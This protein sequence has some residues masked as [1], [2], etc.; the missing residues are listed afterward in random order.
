MDQAIY[1]SADQKLIDDTR[2]IYTK[3]CRY[4]DYE[5]LNQLGKEKITSING[6]LFS[7]EEIYGVNNKD[8]NLNYDIDT[9]AKQVM[10][11]YPNLLN[12]ADANIMITA[13]KSRLGDTDDFCPDF[14]KFSEYK[15]S[16]GNKQYDFEISKDDEYY[17]QLVWNLNFQS[18]FS[19]MNICNHLFHTTLSSEL[20]PDIE[21]IS[22]SNSTLSFSYYNKFLEQWKTTIIVQEAIRY[23]LT[24]DDWIY[25]EKQKEYLQ[26]LNFMPLQGDST[27]Y[28][29]KYQ[30]NLKYMR[31]LYDLNKG[32]IKNI[33]YI[34]FAMFNKQSEST[35][36]EL[37]GRPQL[38][39][40]LDWINSIY[41]RFQDDIMSNFDNFMELSGNIFS[42]GIESMLQYSDFYDFDFKDDPDFGVEYFKP[43][44]DTFI[45]GYKLP[46][47][48][49]K[50][51][52]SC[53]VPIEYPKAFSKDS[54]NKRN[55]EETTTKQLIWKA[56]DS[57]PLF[58]VGKN[59]KGYIINPK[60]YKYIDVFEKKK[61]RNLELEIENF[62]N[63]FNNYSVD[64]EKDFDPKDLAHNYLESMNK[65]LISLSGEKE[66][67]IQSRPWQL[68][69]PINI[70][71]EEFLNNVIGYRVLQN[72]LTDSWRHAARWFGEASRNNPIL[73]PVYQNITQNYR[74]NQIAFE[75]IQILAGRLRN[76]VN[77]ESFN[78]LNAIVRGQNGQGGLVQQVQQINNILNNPIINPATGRP[79]GLIQRVDALEADVAQIKTN[80]A[81]QAK[82]QKSHMIAQYTMMAVN[83]ILNI[84]NLCFTFNRKTSISYSH[85]SES[86]I[87]YWDGGFRTTSFWGMKEEDFKGLNSL[88]L[89]NPI[90]VIKPNKIDGYYYDGKIYGDTYELRMKQTDDVLSGKIKLPNVYN[91]YS[92][93]NIKNDSL[94]SKYHA[95]T[96]DELCDL[97]YK[98]ILQ[99]YYDIN[100]N[101]N[102][103]IPYIAEESEYQADENI[104]V[105]VNK[106][107]SPTANAE[108]IIKAIKPVYYAYL[109]IL[110]ERNQ[111]I[112]NN[113]IKHENDGSIPSTSIPGVS[114]TSNGGYKVNE[115]IYE[116]IIFDPNKD[117]NKDLT[118]EEIEKKMKSE[119]FSKFELPT[120]KVLK[121]DMKYL[122]CFSDFKNNINEIY[123]Y[124]AKGRNGQF[125]YFTN[126][127]DA[128][129]FIWLDYGIEI[130]VSTKTYSNYSFGIYTF[131]SKTDYL[132]WVLANT[133][134]GN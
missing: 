29:N 6:K 67:S 113:S 52:L 133:K 94:D 100:S 23:K 60:R 82:A 3:I 51:V 84:V 89:A 42:I 41:T 75:Q 99:Y 40:D 116:Y 30:K 128:K 7:F 77:T 122:S 15:D 16:E 115:N 108:R 90:E 62:S 24:N 8:L 11:D 118:E 46:I 80:M 134:G 18:N 131:S 1:W 72:T 61:T 55:K 25:T 37:F 130:V 9:L 49:S 112:S 76:T 12:V 88:E 59:G 14:K 48:R 73:A 119:F 117:G 79:H 5:I 56:N 127:N 63:I 85:N 32:E 123:I 74:Y 2:E 126:M 98:D 125:K 28:L 4:Y 96:L 36:E 58:A 39:S 93:E 64:L 44:D 83:L 20:L 27:S 70:T 132:K 21:L 124:E 101:K 22:P 35:L 45:E 87:Y 47:Q 68:F 111:P 107:E 34:M 102:V 91:K 78:E 54:E 53:L 65:F 92:F 109:P 110:N 129:D 57:K 105:T 120:K 13:L 33:I 106:D 81:N 86:G 50:N 97:V 43:G 114:W 26:L 19:M 38:Y 10:D 71:A 104:Y 66:H 95:K 69:G 103:R 121:N 31:E 17:Y